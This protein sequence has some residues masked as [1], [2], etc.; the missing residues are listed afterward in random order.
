MANRVEEYIAKYTRHCSNVICTFP[1]ETPNPYQ[2]WLT[3]DHAR[4]VAQ[5][6]R[7]ETIQRA[8]KW[9]EEHLLTSELDKKDYFVMTEENKQ[10]FIA[11][12]RKAIE[13]HTM[14]KET[15]KCA[16]D[17]FKELP[18]ITSEYEIMD[19]WGYTPTLYYC[20]ATWVVDWVSCIEGDTLISFT[21]KTPEEAIQKAYK[22]YKR[23]FKATNKD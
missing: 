23:K 19:D 11:D 9:L 22:W 4:S 13:E 20:D 3:P 15:T 2:A 12:F 17:Q 8:C 18:H 16:L 6:A 10:C 5:I 1:T 21:G 7:E 14:D